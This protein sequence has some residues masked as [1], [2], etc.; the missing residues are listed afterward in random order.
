VKVI[1]Q[2]PPPLTWQISQIVVDYFSLV[3]STCD[4]NQSQGHWLLNDVLHSTIFMSLK[5][6]EENEILP[7]FKTLIN[8]NSIVNDELS[9]LISNIRREVIIVMDSF[10]SFSKVYDK[11][12]IHNMIS[13][14]LDHKYKSL[15]ILS[16]FVGRGQG[17]ALIEKYDRKSLHPMFKSYEHLRHLVR[18]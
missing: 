16:S 2:V 4:F 6:R 12:K 10:L 13:L 8:E 9:L 3:L 7:S 15:C 14:M 11:R 1:G 17:V 5:L 18:S